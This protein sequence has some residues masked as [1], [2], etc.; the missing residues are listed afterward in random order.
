MAPRLAGDDSL[1]FFL[2]APQRLR[3]TRRWTLQVQPW[4]ANRGEGGA[5]REVGTHFFFGMMELFGER[6]VDRVIANVEYKDGME[7]TGAEVAASGTMRLGGEIFFTS[8]TRV[9]SRGHLGCADE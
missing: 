7:G 3:L 1:C 2:R 8:V 9:R 6:C 4:V 5:L